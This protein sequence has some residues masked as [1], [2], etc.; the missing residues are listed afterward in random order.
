MVVLIIDL[1]NLTIREEEYTGGEAGLRC[2]ISLNREYGPDSLVLSSP[3]YPDDGETLSSWPIVYHSA[4]TDKIEVSTLSSA[5]GYSLYKLGIRALVITGRAE[6]LKYITLSPSRKEILPI[7]NMRAESAVDFERVVVSMNEIAFST[8]RAADKGVYFGSLQYKGRNLP[9]VGLGHAFFLHNLKG[10]VFTSFSS[11]MKNG[12]VE[13]DKARNRFSRLVKA[14]GEYV[15]IPSAAS[16]GWAPVY[17]YSD[18]FDPRL[19]N[20]DGRSM[21]EKFGNYPDGCPGCALK[22][23]RRTKDG[24]SLPSWRDMLLLGPNLGF[25]DPDNIFKIYT[26]ALSCGL[27]VPTLAAV[28]SYIFSLREEERTSYPPLEHTAESVVNYIER[29]STGSLLP[30]GL[31]SLPRAIQGYDHRPVYFDLRGAYSQ[32][33]MLSLGLDMILPAT[34]YFPKKPVNEKCS[35]IF[36]LYEMIYTLALREKG[37]PTS[38]ASTLYWDSVPQ[39]AFRYPIVARYYLRHYTA[40]GFKSRELLE[41]GYGI[42]EKMNLSWHPIPEHFIQDS[43]SS[44][45][46]STV[47]LKRLQDYFDEE[48]VRLLISLKSRRDRMVRDEGV[49]RAKEG[50]EEDLGSETEPGLRK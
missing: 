35:A 47:H 18:R 22:C 15:V 50:P 32:A 9:G 42:F 23:L 21:A 38:M 1:K 7:E 44:L 20:I 40:Y 25:F 14:Y 27:E 2:A 4:I 43:S 34:L 3:D 6:K 24:E 8:G 17:N 28:L 41:L 33:L 30:K 31:E 49:R 29:I 26:S 39:A 10:I 36:A 16:L 5:H 12:D 48:K 37:Y 46:A 19:A 13:T 45:D 11:Y